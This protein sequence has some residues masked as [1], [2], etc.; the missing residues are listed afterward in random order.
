[1]SSIKVNL[2]GKEHTLRFGVL[3]VQT[4]WKEISKNMSYYMQS[5]QLVI[6]PATYGALINAYFAKSEPIDFTFEDVVNWVDEADKETIA[7]IDKAFSESNKYKETLAELEN[8][9]HVGS[10]VEDEKKN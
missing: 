7:A 8:K 3:A 10:S 5:Q 9:L 2:G 4:F 6:Y 1:M